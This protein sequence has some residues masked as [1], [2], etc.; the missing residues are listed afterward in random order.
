M[1]RESF[2]DQKVADVLNESFISIKVDREERPDVDHI[3]M[4]VCQVLTGSGGWP[5]TIIMTPEKRPFFAGTY[6]PKTGKRGMQSLLDI[7]EA[8]KDAWMNKRDE[9]VNT[10]DK[11]VEAIGG[12]KEQ[13]ST[14]LSED[15]LEKAF[16]LFDSSFDNRFGGFREAPKFPTP[17]NLLFLLRYWHTAK[18]PRALEMV[19]KTLDSMYSGGIYDHIGYGFSRY[20]T[21]R[22]WIVPH[23]EKML[24]D[25]ALLAIAYL[26]CYQ[27]TRIEKYGRIAEE[28]F[29]YVLRDM[30]A[31][32]GGFL[33]AEDAD[34]EGVE[35]KF[36]IWKP[37]EIKIILGDEAGKKFCNYY[38]ITKMDNFEGQNIPNLIHGEIPEHDRSFINKCR[39]KLFEYRENR[40]HPYKDDKILTAW[41]GLMIAA[42]AIGGRVLNNNR[43]T[44]AAEKAMEF[45]LEKLVREDGRLLARYRDGESALLAYADDY[46]FVIW[47]LIELYETTYNPVYLQKAINLNKEFIGLFWDNENKGFFLYGKDAEQLLSRPKEIY[48]GAIPS[49]NSVEALNLIRLSRLTADSSYEEISD[50]MIS[51]F[52]RDIN[53]YPSGYAFALISILYKKSKS[54]EIVV[55][56]EKEQEGKEMLEL[57]NSFYMPFAVT[58][59]ITANKDKLTDIVANV[60]NYEAIEDKPS[61]YICEGFACKQ[62]VN[63]IGKLKQMLE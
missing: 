17:H 14:K 10:S 54:K 63:S 51:I 6:F 38:G 62:P 32:S 58:L 59:H 5:L 27:A 28:I 40:V 56:T 4:E 24:Y 55:V 47:A 43:Y 57:I 44:N 36:Y 19:K 12:R 13:T 49:G 7:L 31:D 48:D 16:K 37:E 23:F 42:M 53:G 11:I 21:D 60:N 20:S 29:A 61:A 1:E 41:N 22:E 33:S 34:S 52:S 30:T 39:E 46:A 50:D 18:K 45:I 25:N 35:G 3:Y 26:E 15:V 8:V 9:L 2:E